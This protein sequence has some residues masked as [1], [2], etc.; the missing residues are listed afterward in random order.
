MIELAALLFVSA[1]AITFVTD[2][3][4]GAMKLVRA[5]RRRGKIHVASAKHG[6]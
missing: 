5:S 3:L 2:A 1:V 6:R 4:S